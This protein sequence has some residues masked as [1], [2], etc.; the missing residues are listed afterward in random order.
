[1][2]KLIST[3]P[4]RGYEKLGEVDI[5][6]DA[7]IQEKVAQANNAKRQWKELGVKK[8]A[9]LSIGTFLGETCR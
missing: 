9:E 1:M 2:T 3:N 8:R 6:S 7:E 5:S 4:A